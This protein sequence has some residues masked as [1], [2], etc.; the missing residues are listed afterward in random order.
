MQLIPA[1]KLQGYYSGNMEM[2]N[3][4]KVWTCY[5]IQLYLLKMWIYYRCPKKSFSENIQASTTD[6]SCEISELFRAIL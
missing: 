4:S 6:V 5:L 2:S 1:T 3:L